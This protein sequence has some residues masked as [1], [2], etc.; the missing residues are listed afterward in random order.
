VY[1]E[2][3]VIADARG[4]ARAHFLA[5]RAAARAALAALAVADQPLPTGAGGEVRWPS[6]VRGSVSHTDGLAIAGVARADQVLGVGVDVERAD[7][8]LRAGV[9]RHVATEAELAW[10]A[11]PPEL[12]AQP[13]LLLV[14]AKEV[15]FKAFFEHTG[16]R[17]GFHDA[18]LT[19]VE[20]GMR[21]TVLRDLGTEHRELSV[22]FVRVGDHI[23]ALGALARAGISGGG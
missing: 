7:R 10:L 9:P 12:P 4:K 18:E 20:A 11:R 19:P 3:R 21:A 23:V 17:L 2:E 8:E 14:S 6:G 22:R 15:V 1:E 5:G 13:L 16:V